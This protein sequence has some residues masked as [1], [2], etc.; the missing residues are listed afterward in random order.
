MNKNNIKEIIITS[1]T[2]VILVNGVIREIWPL[3]KESAFENPADFVGTY[4]VQDSSDSTIAFR[5]VPV[6]ID[7]D[8]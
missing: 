8:Y 2:I 5:V 7:L 4:L 6:I 3:E 1:F